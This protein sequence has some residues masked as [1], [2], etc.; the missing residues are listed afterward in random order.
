M[1]D[2]SAMAKLTKFDEQEDDM[3][4]F[5]EQ[6]EHKD[7][8]TVGLSPLLMGNGLDVYTSMPVPQVRDYDE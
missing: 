2:D 1:P 6:F 3:D 5:L 8:W 4:A 7:V